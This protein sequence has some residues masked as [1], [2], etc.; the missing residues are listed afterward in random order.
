MGYYSI[1]FNQIRDILV[2]IEQ[3]IELVTVYLL[4]QVC[5]CKEERERRER[6]SQVQDFAL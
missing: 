3:R 4:H 5:V 1:D 6:C 2:N